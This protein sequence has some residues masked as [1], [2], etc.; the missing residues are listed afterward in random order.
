LLSAQAIAQAALAPVYMWS[1]SADRE[2]II[3][4]CNETAEH[5]WSQRRPSIGRTLDLIVPKEERTNYWRN[6][7]RDMKSGVLNRRA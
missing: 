5:L 3:R 4:D 1:S 7:R 6:F 2:G